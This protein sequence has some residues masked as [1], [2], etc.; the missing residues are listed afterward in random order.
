MDYFFRGSNDAASSHGSRLGDAISR[1]QMRSKVLPVLFPWHWKVGCRVFCLE[2]WRRLEV[3]RLPTMMIVSHSN[4]IC[5]PPN[6]AIHHDAL[7]SLNEFLIASPSRLSPKVVSCVHTTVLNYR[8]QLS[9]RPDE[10]KH[11]QW[12]WWLR[13]VRRFFWACLGFFTICPYPDTLLRRILLHLRKAPTQTSFVFRTSSAMIPHKKSRKTAHVR[14]TSSETH[15]SQTVARKLPLKF[16]GRFFTSSIKCWT[17]NVAS[18]LA[19]IAA[20][21]NVRFGDCG[22]Q[23]SQFSGS[24]NQATIGNWRMQ[25]DGR[26]VVRYRASKQTV[27]M[28]SATRDF[29]SFQTAPK[30]QLNREIEKSKESTLC[31]SAVAVAVAFTWLTIWICNFFHSWKCFSMQMTRVRVDQ[32]EERFKPLSLTWMTSFGNGWSGALWLDAGREFN[33][34]YGNVG[35]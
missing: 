9:I 21:H 25:I 34:A 2:A 4:F 11:G 13:S 27:T 16:C 29:F 14:P 10:V 23:R 7:L 28:F 6:R 18:M 5:F 33:E 30:F 35:G 22:A 20:V 15:L 32:V 31:I 1:A 8:S 12:W 17:V 26:C 3:N 19:L 24:T